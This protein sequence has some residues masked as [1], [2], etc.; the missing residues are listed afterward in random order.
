M[1]RLN[2]A[3]RA[4]AWSAAH[5]RRA[6]VGWFVF[7]ALAAALGGALGTKSDTNEGSG[8]SGR[9][10]AFLRQHFP[11]SSTE[12]VLIQARRGTLATSPAYRPAVLAVTERIARVPHVTDVWA[13]GSG[14]QRGSVSR[15]GRSALVTF[16]LGNRGNVTRTLGTTAALARAYPSL[17]IEEFGDASANKALNTSLGQDFSRA[18]TL[19]IPITLLILVLAFG[20]LVAAGVPML[21]GMS[22]VGA[23]LG[24]IGVVSQV[25]PMDSSISSVVLLIGL[26]V[27]VDYSLFYLRREREERAAGASQQAALRAAAATSG[28]AIQISALTVMAA[29]AGMFFA[30]SRV[31]T[32]FAIGTII[33]VATA[34]V[35]SLTVL[36]AM[37]AALGPR[38]E[39]GRVP[40]LHRF[41]RASAGESRVWSVLLH[42]VM[43]R[44]AL[45]A[46]AS[47][48]ALLVL[49]VPVLHMQT[50]L[51][52]NASLPRSL[53][54][55]KT[56]DRIQAAFPGGS[57]PAVVGI[58]ARDVR[59]AAVQGGVQRLIARARVTPGLLQPMTVA[60]SPD[61]RAET[62][63]V[64]LAGNGTSSRSDRALV[65]LRA[66]LPQT[67]GAAPGVQ[68]GVTG[69]TA[70]T[71]DFDAVMN[72]HLP[73]VFVFVFGM[74]FLLL[75]F[76]FRSI[77][78]PLQAIALNLLSIGAAYGVLVLV[79]QDGVLGSLL[80]V[81][82]RNPIT[83]W[84]P[85]FMFVV[86][87]GLS[88][89]YHVFILSRVKEAFD[90]G[91][92]AR[93]AV[94]RGV[95]GTAGVVT[96]AALV[97]VAVFSIFG[98]LS[99]IEFKQLGV[100]L[101]AAILLDATVIRG[102]LLPSTL[103]L[104]GE[105]AWYL[106]A[107]LEWL[108]G[109]SRRHRAGGARVDPERG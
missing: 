103:A 60:I 35:G 58:Q 6:I 107:W 1:Q 56:Y 83:S 8:Q 36:P 23:T 39:K 102:V 10:D 67:V 43:R 65:R 88:M 29:M 105:R 21:L 64:P 68:A 11:K 42:G 99:M 82:G 98:T 25:L 94:G 14:G 46:G 22:A 73:I 20:A 4:G 89:D 106:P 50:A 34:M 61:H 9:T 57:S 5:R 108:P 81:Q 53:P 78:I 47:A 59:A 54:I 16:E 49:A 2:L 41:R 40:L 52:G 95:R 32:S 15:D 18:E 30:G 84:L 19:S 109:G 13:P 37:M 27:G 63:S 72:S 71:V 85:L 74:A 90:S 97:M 38:I 87:F 86:L 75:L 93:D 48:T 79:F 3:A 101:A 92:G 51:P 96:S 66:L 76:T 26:A 28:H 45:A 24:L 100:G 70:G 33:V 62:I 91:L 55:V 104:L 7:V 80:G 31:F 44:P 12:T 69:D 77:V 17:R